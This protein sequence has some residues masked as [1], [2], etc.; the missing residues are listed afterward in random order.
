MRTGVWQP[1]EE[2]RFRAALAREREEQQQQ[3]G[4]AAAAAAGAESQQQQQQ[5][6]AVAVA[7][8]GAGEAGQQQQQEEGKIRW[9]KVRGTRTRPTFYCY[10]VLRPPL[11]AAHFLRI[12]CEWLRTMLF[13][14]SSFPLET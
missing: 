5:Q 12:P 14:F 4:G 11:C 6:G 7:G 8:A 3:G 10:I 2:E 9:S 13:S 1:D